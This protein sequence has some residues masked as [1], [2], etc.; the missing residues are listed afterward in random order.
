[1]ISGMYL[2]EIVRLVCVHLTSKG[3]LF[4]GVCTEKLGKREEFLTKFVSDVER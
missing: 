1:M 2:G 4:G 3:L